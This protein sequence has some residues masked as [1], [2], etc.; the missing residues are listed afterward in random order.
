VEHSAA[1]MVKGLKLLGY[2]K[3]LDSGYQNQQARSQHREHSKAKR[4]AS[5]GNNVYMMI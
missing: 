5:I 4:G 1:F 3:P 2:E